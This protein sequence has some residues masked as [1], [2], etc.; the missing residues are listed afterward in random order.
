MIV[1]ICSQPWCHDC[2]VGDGVTR[3]DAAYSSVRLGAIGMGGANSKTW[4]WRHGP[5]HK[6]IVDVRVG[7]MQPSAGGF[8]SGS[9]GSAVVKGSGNLKRFAPQ[10]CPLGSVT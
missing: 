1:D 10:Q 5:D 9:G 7:P 6:L 8:E 4:H 3:I 2:D